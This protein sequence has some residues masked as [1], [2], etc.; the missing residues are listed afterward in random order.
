MIGIAYDLTEFPVTAENCDVASIHRRTGGFNLNDASL[1]SGSYL[2]PLAPLAIDFATRKAVAVKNVKVVENAAANATAIKVKKESLAYTGMFLGN[3]SLAKQVTAVDRTNANYDLLT[4]SL[5]A[6]VTVG[7]VLFET[8]EPATAVA[9]VKGV[10]KLTIGTNATAADKLTIGGVDYTFAAASGEGVI[11]VGASATATAAN[12][13]DALSAQYEGIFSVKAD[14]AKL[15][16]TQLVG[17]TGAIPVVSVTQTGGGT[18]VASIATTTA[19]VA[20]VV[21]NGTIKNVA[22]H[23]NYARTKVET[24][25]IV[26]AIFAVD[27]VIES[28]LIVPLS[29]PDKVNLGGRFDII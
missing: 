21:A 13:E 27:E 8:N 2:P 24:G 11:A 17:G 20:L 22:N 23:L 14:G 12:L 3:G 5:T 29:A 9:E 1:V 18:L 4:I 7:Q 16:F 25:A 19:G 15:V 26:D 28:K 10:H 6:S